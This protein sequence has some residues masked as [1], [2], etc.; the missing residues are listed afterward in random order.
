LQDRSKLIRQLTR[1]N[2]SQSNL[3][4]GNP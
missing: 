2:R 1:R 4:N 3:V